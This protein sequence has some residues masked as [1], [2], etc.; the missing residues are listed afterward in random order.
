MF[1]QL[2]ERIQCMIM[3]LNLCYGLWRSPPIW[4]MSYWFGLPTPYS[5]IMQSLSHGL[6]L[7][8]LT[9]SGC[10]VLRTFW[11]T[12]KWWQLLLWSWLQHKLPELLHDESLVLHCSLLWSPTPGLACVL[13]VSKQWLHLFMHALHTY[14][15]FFWKVVSFSRT[16]FSW[17]L[18]RRPVE[19]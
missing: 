6:T 19:E 15:S 10:L 12:L 16:S 7:R 14:D 1:R 17:H 4:I 18:Q 2:F 13:S 11:W 5:N 3:V 8:N 9:R